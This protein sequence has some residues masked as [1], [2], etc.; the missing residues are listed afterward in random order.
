M[1]Q[2]A[3][4]IALWMTVFWVCSL[5]WFPLGGCRG[6]EPD[7]NEAAASKG[8][9]LS[10]T[11]KE[12]KAP[13]EQEENK[14]P[15]HES[16]KPRVRMKTS[17]GDIVLELNRKLAPVSVENFLEY[18]RSGAYDGTIFHRVIPRFMI[19]G[20]GFDINMAKRPTRSPIRNEADNGLKNLR[21]T[22]AMART[23]AVNSATN[24]FFINCKDN[25]FLNH[26]GKDPRSYGYAVFGKVAEGMDVVDRIEKVPTGNKGH[27]Q[28]VPKENVIIESVQV[29]SP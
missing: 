27:F 17:E 3:K 2:N 15:V 12:E 19:Q 29:E 4:G 10:E 14:T 23:S 16:D 20:G 9:T 18:V 26:R 24:Q 22:I 1:K 6:E 21:G 13:V 7:R 25:D 8:T 5:L 28:D 11:K